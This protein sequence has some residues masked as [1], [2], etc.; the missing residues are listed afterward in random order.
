[1]KLVVISVEADTAIVVSAGLAWNVSAIGSL[2]ERLVKA[3]LWSTQTYFPLRSS[4]SRE[5][6]PVNSP[7]GGNLRH[8][9]AFAS[10]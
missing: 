9:C 10:H 2:W 1:M 7:L 5:R 3:W 6:D 4:S 8:L